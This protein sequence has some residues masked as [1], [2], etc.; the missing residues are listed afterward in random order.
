MR[1]GLV[2]L[3]RKFSSFGVKEGEEL[4]YEKGQGAGAQAAIRLKE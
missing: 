3:N 4:L 2:E 1:L